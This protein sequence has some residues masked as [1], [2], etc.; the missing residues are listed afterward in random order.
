M[1]TII[2][3]NAT[4]LP[5]KLAS[6]DISKKNRWFKDVLRKGGFNRVMMG[7]A[8]ISWEPNYYQL[9]WHVAMWTANPKELTAKLK[10]L[11]PGDAPYDRPALV[12]KTYDLGFLAYKDKGIKLP[13]LLRDNRRHLAEL[14]LA[15]DRTEPLDLL[16]L[17]K[18]RMSTKQGKL[19]LKKIKS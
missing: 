7:S 13:D 18:L 17:Q 9:H 19:V 3:L 5:G 11:F 8:D 15:L 16:I 6:L 1:A 14:L 4:Y 10:K 12:S 2:P